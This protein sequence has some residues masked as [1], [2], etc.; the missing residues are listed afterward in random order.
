MEASELHR[1][2]LG[3][4]SLE[5]R[6]LPSAGTLPISW[7]APHLHDAPLTTLAVS[8]YQRDGGLTRGDVIGLFQEVA[9]D[10]T[11]RNRE[12]QDLH[13]LVNNGA[14]LGMSQDVLDLAGKVVGFD[15]AN[16]HFQGR[17]LEPSGRLVA[18]TRGRVLDALVDKWFLGEDHPALTH[19][20]IVAGV[21]YETVQG[22]LFG[23]GGPTIQD[24][25]QGFLGD[26]F[27]PASLGALTVRD[28]AAIHAMFID[29]GDGTYSVRFY[30]NVRG[31]EQAEW[32]TVD[33]SLPVDPNGFL[34][35]CGQGQ[36]A[37]DPNEVLWLALVEKA[38]CQLSASGW[39]D[40]DRVAN[41]YAAIAAGG[42]ETDV[43]QQVLGEA[44]A[45]FN[46]AAE[47]DF[48]Q[49]VLNG[50]AVTLD[51]KMHEPS[52]SQV[53]ENHAYYVTGYDASTN[54]YTII[55]PWGANFND[56]QGHPGTLH[57][58]WSQIT[59]T[60]DFWDDAVIPTV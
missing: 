6:A 53:L 18:G 46:V 17:L 37:N 57:L 38:Y 29:N 55:N 3:I 27:L 48:R 11:V 41:S 1:T 32:V 12:L 59:Q 5:D 50:D 10:G 31:Q 42:F 26:C 52:G 44:S 22:Q 54:T 23:P 45:S 21:S 51:T 8:D 9:S 20:A 39:N 15:R 36:A 34:F 2:R 28:P 30:R 35:Y 13:T 25:D 7:F 4:E 60:F 14:A 19:Q 24:I 16:T 43:F 47:P 56:G 40:A 58:N 49:A 33:R